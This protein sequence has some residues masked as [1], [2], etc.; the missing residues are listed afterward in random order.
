MGLFHAIAWDC[1]KL[2]HYLEREGVYSLLSTIFHPFIRQTLV[3]GSSA[4]TGYLKAFLVGKSDWFPLI[5]SIT[6]N[7]YW[8]NSGCGVPTLH[9][10]N[11]LVDN[12]ALPRYYL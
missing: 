2:F 12:P 11:L 10:Y 3:I 7:K 5:L 6:E 8:Q 9:P 4:R 1:S